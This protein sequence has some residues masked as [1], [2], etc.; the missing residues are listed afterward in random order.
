MDGLKF[1][2]AKKE[3]ENEILEFLLKF[4]RE[5]EPIS[6]SIKMSRDDG[7]TLFKDLVKEGLQSPVSFVCLNETGEVIGCRLNSVVDLKNK[8]PEHEYDVQPNPNYTAVS[9]KIE[10]FL[11][12]IC[13]DLH[14]FIPDCKKY[15]KFLMV[16]VHPKYQRRGIAKKLI[17]LSMDMAKNSDCDYI[18]V[19][20]T[21][22]NS[23]QLFK[24]LQFD[25]LRTIDHKDFL[26]DQQPVFN[27]DDG[28]NCAKLMA[29]KL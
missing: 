14:S 24:K 10:R 7:Y 15:M 4:F 17:E 8:T 3:Q 18:V 26:E 27:C 29:K 6:R 16:S 5:D 1:E 28:T 20:A 2:I 11:D 21:A 22:F 19:A 25:T 9:Q 13:K 23:Q 12:E